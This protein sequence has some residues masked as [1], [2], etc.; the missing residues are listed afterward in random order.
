MKLTCK[1]M[2]EHI[3]LLQ[4][5]ESNNEYKNF[6]TSLIQRTIN[7]D[8]LPNYLSSITKVD[9][10]AFAYCTDLALT[11]LPEGITTI[12]DYAF[13]VCYDLALT[14]LPDNLVSIGACAFQ[15]CSKLAITTIPASVMEIGSR[16][17]DICE[18][19]SITFKGTPTSIASDAFGGC[20]NLTTINVPWSEGEVANAPWGATN[21]TINYNYTGE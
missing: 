3:K 4:L 2:I 8:T 16:A 18:F 14:K 12:G 17:F 9:K 13:Y 1:Q 19:S 15:L 11:S 6:L 10:A 7:V 5:P 21:A 20:R